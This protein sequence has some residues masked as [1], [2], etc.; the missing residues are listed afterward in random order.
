VQVDSE[1]IPAEMQTGKL[2]CQLK[3]P[4]GPTAWSWSPGFSLS[5]KLLYG[6]RKLEGEAYRAQLV[7]S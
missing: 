7:D 6:R 4:S 3:K 5:F 1:P 2:V